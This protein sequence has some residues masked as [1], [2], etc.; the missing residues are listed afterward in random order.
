MRLLFIKIF[1]IAILYPISP[2]SL[3]YLR[4]DVEGSGECRF[5]V[6]RD[7]PLPDPQGRV[8]DAPGVGRGKGVNFVNYQ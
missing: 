7:A 2:T 8:L 3:L 1:N 6:L 5:V 4:E